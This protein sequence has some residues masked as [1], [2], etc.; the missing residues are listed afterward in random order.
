M[1]RDPKNILV[2][3]LSN[4]GDVILTTPV[5]MALL[6]RFP[7]AKITVVVGPRAQG[8][9][10]RSSALHRVVIYDK[11]A[12]LF[13]KLMFILELRGEKYDWV[14][15]LRNTAIPFL[16]SCKKRSPLFRKF[17]QVNMRERHLEVLGMTGLKPSRPPAPF[18]FF[19]EVDE[20]FAL[21]ALDAI[22]VQE[23]NDWILIAAGAASARK[24]WPAEKFRDL[25]KRL[26]EK[27]GKK[28]LLVGALSERPVAEYIAVEVPGAVKILC[29]DLT[30]AETAAL[31]SKASLLVAN[32]SALMHLGYE[33]GTPTVGIFGP[34]NHDKYG[35]TGPKFRIA[36]ADAAQCKCNSHT[37]PYAK[38]SC[39]HG[40]SVDRVFQLSMELL[41][42]T[43]V[44]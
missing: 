4:I 37:L 15:D 28:I 36:R 18:Q 21:R 8:I 3:T 23:I 24:R 31:V 41:N 26:H 10:Q 9:L 22:G 33:L 14:V 13:L 27:T 44:S 2:V 6:E 43:Q 17:T 5:M 20:I 29:G 38:R 19:N 16:V 35:H 11:K 25:V 30:L 12:A 40:L 1:D 7:Q 42:G 32:D 34:T 39:F